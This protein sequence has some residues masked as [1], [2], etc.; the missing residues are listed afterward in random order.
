MVLPG[1]LT[2]HFLINI[3][4]VS[5][6]TLPIGTLTVFLTKNNGVFFGIEVQS[7]I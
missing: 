6:K 2:V 1:T 7:H 4:W 3:I 5:D